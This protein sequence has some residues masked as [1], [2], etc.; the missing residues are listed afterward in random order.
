MFLI[1]QQWQCGVVNVIPKSNGKTEM[2][3][4]KWCYPSSESLYQA[5]NHDKGVL[6]KPNDILLFACQNFCSDK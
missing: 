3:Y 6:F 4:G 1:F 2:F 5:Q